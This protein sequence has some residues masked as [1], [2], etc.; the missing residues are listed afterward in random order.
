[1]DKQTDR[2]TDRHMRL[3]AL[4]HAGDYTTG[5]SNYF[6]NKQANQHESRR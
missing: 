5:V 3:N 2:Q 1:V 6:A 4:H